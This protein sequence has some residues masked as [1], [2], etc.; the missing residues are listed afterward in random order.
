MLP[1]YKGRRNSSERTE[2]DLNQ[3]KQNQTLRKNLKGLEEEKE[4]SGKYNSS[5]EW[6]EYEIGQ[7]T[8]TMKTTNKKVRQ[9]NNKRQTKIVKTHVLVAKDNVC[10]WNMVLRIKFGMGI[11]LWKL[12][13]W[14]P[15]LK[16]LQIV[17]HYVNY[18]NVVHAWK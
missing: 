18:I 17:I 14:R 7:S 12:F 11:S 3:Q 13:K 6:D 9:C 5:K 8:T 2:R 15:N 16:F 1:C 10:W 4:E